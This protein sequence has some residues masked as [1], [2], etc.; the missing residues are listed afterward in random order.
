MEP[1]TVP[2]NEC[3]ATN[4]NDIHESGYPDR[5]RDRDQ[6]IMT[7]YKCNECGAEGKHFEHNHQGT[8]QLSGALRV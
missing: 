4:W 6:T 1:N 5:R 3:G 7:I 8:E 2:C